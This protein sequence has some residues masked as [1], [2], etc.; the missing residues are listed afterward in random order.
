MYLDPPK[1]LKATTPMPVILVSSRFGEV[2]NVAPY[3]WHMPISMDPPLL[4]IAIRKERDTYSNILDTGEFVVNVPGKDLVE[5]IKETA[6]P[7]PRDV[8]EFEKA[9]LTPL[10]SKMVN[11]ASVLECLTS[12][13]CKLEWTKE[14]GD[15]DVVVGRVVNVRVADKMVE[16][17]IDDV[18]PPSLIHIGGGRNRYATIGDII[19]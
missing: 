1:Y 13:E 17:G 15:H 10:R 14:A 11:V 12:I 18:H 2:M 9:G 6:K 16:A 5:A 4:G 8:S 7:F 3:A 19:G